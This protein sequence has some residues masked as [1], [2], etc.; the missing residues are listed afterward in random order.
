VGDHDLP[1]LEIRRNGAFGQATVTTLPPS[2]LRN[3]APP[4]THV[5]AGGAG[6][7]GPAVIDVSGVEGGG[8]RGV[9]A[10]SKKRKGRLIGR[11]VFILG[12]LFFLFT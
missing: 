10:R 7:A 5:G 12:S 8:G 6:R 9:S 1:P 11:G 3:V 4:G 2:Q